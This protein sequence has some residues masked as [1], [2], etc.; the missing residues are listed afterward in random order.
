MKADIETAYRGARS[1]IANVIRSLQQQ[2]PADVRAAESARRELQAISQRVEVAERPHRAARAPAAR[3]VDPSALL[4]GVRLQIEG[5]PRE[6]VLLEGPDRHGRIVVRSGS[7]RVAVPCQRVLR[8]LEALP[9]RPRPPQAFID[10]RRGPAPEGLSPECDLRGLRVDE[11]LDRA[12]AH[13]HSVLA[14]GAPSASFIHGHGTGALRSAIRSWLR[15]A[16]G[17]RSFGPAAA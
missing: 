10:V 17:V 12:D 3:S 15:S 13:L 2:P 6:A 1:E 11:A 7:W 16:P 5:L 14:T 8:V 4:P 9:E